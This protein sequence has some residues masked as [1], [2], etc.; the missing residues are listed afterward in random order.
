MLAVELG[1]GA[2][3]VP[4]SWWS[5]GVPVMLLGRLCAAGCGKVYR[6]SHPAVGDTG[7]LVPVVG[8]E[9]LTCALEVVGGL[10]RRR[11]RG[12]TH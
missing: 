10:G 8:V 2:G 9:S 11:E 4:A 5:T 1:V 6:V 12:V 7:T 3:A